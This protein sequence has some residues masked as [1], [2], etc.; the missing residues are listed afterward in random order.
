MSQSNSQSQTPQNPTIGEDD[1]NRLMELLAG[2]GPQNIEEFRLA[3]AKELQSLI[4]FIDHTRREISSLSNEDFREK[5]IHSAADEL[6]AVV[7]ATEDAT[8]TIMDNC[9]TIQDTIDDLDS[10]DLSKPINDAVMNIYEACSFQDITGQRITKVVAALQ[11]IEAQLNQL[12]SAVG[13]DDLP[14]SDDAVVDTGRRDGE[15]LDEDDLL[16]GPQLPG[17]GIDQDEVD[18]LFD[19]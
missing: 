10:D 7:D 12:L 14:Q 19:D 6:D 4:H 5:Y 13:G 3:V 17:E 9:E 16:N 1:I 18:R 15:N 11:G 2:N 8:G